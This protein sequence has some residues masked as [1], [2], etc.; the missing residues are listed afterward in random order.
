M[1]DVIKDLL[2]DMYVPIFK[3]DEE[4]HQVMLHH[5]HLD[6]IKSS[7]TQIDAKL[8][9]VIEQCIS[10]FRDI[11]GLSM[12]IVNSSEGYFVQVTEHG[13]TSVIERP[14]RDLEEDLE[15]GDLPYELFNIT[16]DLYDIFY[17]N[18][19]DPESLG[20]YY[21]SFIESVVNILC[22]KVILA[23]N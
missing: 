7:G 8:R 11:Y 10:I 22:S 9:A 14:F 3:V 16:V 12:K 17:Y 1:N 20:H 6:I 21:R 18:T 4:M 5:T 15:G 19:Y 23:F 13:D 2:D